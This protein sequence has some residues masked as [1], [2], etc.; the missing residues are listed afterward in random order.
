MFNKS[1]LIGFE[2]WVADAFEEKQVRGPIHLSGGNERELIKIFHHIT[3]KDWVFST[4]RNHYHFILKV[5]EPRKLQSLI[6]EGNSMHTYDKDSKFFTS[7]IVGGCIPIAVGVAL[8]IQRKG[9]DE[10]VWCFIGDGATDSGRFY[11]AARYA[12]SRQLPIT[13]VIE[14]NDLSCSTTKEERWGK[15]KDIVDRFYCVIRYK[16]KRTVEHT[17]SGTWVSF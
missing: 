10:H 1:Y 3:A 8:S 7:A 5:R 2:R 13:F 17:G 11:E 12:D 15:D 9:G 16:Y 14:D 6:M 4:H